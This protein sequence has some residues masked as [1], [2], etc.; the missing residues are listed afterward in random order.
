MNT[1]L[2]RFCRYVRVGTMAD[3]KATTYPS[4]PGQLELGR[5]LTQEL[6]ALGLRDAAQDQHGIV[7]ATIPP[8][9][10]HAAPTIALI[11]HVDTSPET[12]GTNVKPMVH[13]NYDGD[14]IVLPGNPSKVLRAADNP[15]LVA[16]KGKT[17]ITTDGTTL[18][19]CDDKG[20]VAVIMETAAVLLGRREV[21]HGPIRICFTCD[22]EIGRG[23]DHVDLSK[24]GAVVG[25]TLDGGGQGEIDNE[26][27]SADLAVVSVKGVNIH[28]SIGKGRMI[29]A[30]RLAG[31]FLERLPRLCLSPETTAD[32][33]GFLH[34]YRIEG[35]VAEVTMRILLRDFDTAGLAERAELLRTVARTVTAD[36]PGATIDVSVTPQYRNMADGLAREPRAVAFAQEAMR[37]AGVEPKLT[38]VRGGTDGSRL[39]ELGLPTPNLSTGEHNIHSPLEWTCL[40]EMATAVRVLVE[41][42]RTW[43]AEKAGP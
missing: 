33:E 11:A 12:S 38:I 6:Q 42:A 23:V 31:L 18:L 30:V 1:L 21:S 9:V 39:T 26:T 27:F 7:L 41:L 17:I 29:N 13:A 10:K 35:G 32:R 22:E 19:G 36:Y 3:E 43:G 20:G 37:R 2:E 14:D 16:C 34:P 24:L 40:E 8:T 4:S 15:E 28:P 5:M 25:Y